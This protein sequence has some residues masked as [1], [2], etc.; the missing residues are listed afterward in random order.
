MWERF[1]FK[2][3]FQNAGQKSRTK[4]G[5][6]VLPM[7][8]MFTLMAVYIAGTN[9]TLTELVTGEKTPPETLKQSVK[10]TFGEMAKL[11]NDYWSE[12]FAI[13]NN[14]KNAILFSAI[15]QLGV[16]W[17]HAIT[18]V[19]GLATQVIAQ[20]V[21]KD[22]CDAAGLTEQQCIQKIVELIFSKPHAWLEFAAY[23]VMASASFQ[24]VGLGYKPK[25]KHQGIRQKVKA[26]GLDMITWLL[27][28]MWTQEDKAI[29]KK[30]LV[31]LGISAGIASLLILIAALFE[32]TLT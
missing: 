27:P 1:V 23:G 21:V 10:D 9:P 19:T 32:A 17:M 31:W 6:I 12:V 24:F 8:F 5:K 18:F 3:V 7:I 22:K 29:A 30:Q 25:E 11:K 16:T 4:K 2:G 14:N 20:E 28:W 13:W 15:P 26:A